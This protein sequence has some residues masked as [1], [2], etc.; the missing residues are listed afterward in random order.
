L[1]FLS[2]T[3]YGGARYFLTGNCLNTPEGRSLR[4][5]V[6]ED[7]WPTDCM[8]HGPLEYYFHIPH[9]QGIRREIVNFSDPGAFPD[10]IRNALTRGA[11]V[12][13]G[14]PFLDQ[15][16]NM[17]ERGTCVAVDEWYARLVECLIRRE[18]AREDARTGTAWA[19][20]RKAERAFD[21]LALEASQVF[22][23]AF[24]DPANRTPA[25]R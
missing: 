2:Y 1:R 5:F 19:H 22:W 8:G 17:L 16:Y 20:Y 18:R 23:T 14:V 4:R 7:R 9:R 3:E 12:D 21:V 10:D 6:T 13:I 15:W 11:F 25:W 24:R